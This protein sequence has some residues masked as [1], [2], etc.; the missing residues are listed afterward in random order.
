MSECKID[1]ETFTI[2]QLRYLL[3]QAGWSTSGNKDQLC[4]RL[5]E[6]RKSPEYARLQAQ[7]TLREI[8]RPVSPPRFIRPISPP[9]LEPTPTPVFG[10]PTALPTISRPISPRLFGERT[11]PS[12]RRPVS[13]PRFQ[14][15]ISS[16]SPP[17]QV[18][19]FGRPT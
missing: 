4:A 5:R 14:L 16:P 10:R 6:D 15:P 7:Q 18:V 12:I 11:P 9:R 1:D 3:D 13:P 8:H 17:T 2:Y 19:E